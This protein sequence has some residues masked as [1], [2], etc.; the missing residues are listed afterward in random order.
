M[1]VIANVATWRDGRAL[2][3]CV[4]SI[5]G[6]VD[7][8]VLLP[9]VLE[10]L[11]P[12]LGDYPPDALED[13]DLG[14]YHDGTHVHVIGAP[15]GAWTSLSHKR[16]VGRQYAVNH[17]DADWILAIDADEILRNGELLRDTLR[18]SPYLAFPIPFVSDD[19]GKVTRAPWKVYRAGRWTH[20]AQSSFM[21]LEAGVK[22]VTYQLEP[23]DEKGLDRAIA[24]MLPYLE[25][26]PEW[27]PDWRQD[28]ALRLGF[29]ENHLEPPPETWTLWRSPSVF[30]PDLLAWRP[31]VHTDETPTHYCPAC[32]LRFF[33][34]GVCDRAH[35][36]TRVEPLPPPDA[37]GADD[38][39]PAADPAGPDLAERIEAYG[40]V[41]SPGAEPVAGETHDGEPAS[42][43]HPDT[44]YPSLVPRIAALEAG[45]E[46]VAVRLSSL[47]T[48]T[49]GLGERV[50]AFEANG[51]DA[52]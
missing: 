7:A 38:S 8:I 37:D 41:P 24:E 14:R 12:I 16:E 47:E 4:R 52:E 25:H 2:H 10:P 31:D 17:L 43:S 6:H 36:P 23:Q 22:S 34:P 32:G 33:A 50:R 9:G 29:T 27:R 45:L 18:T 42:V 30:L 46:N 44:V 13:E 28:P 48:Y 26:H 49:E 11:V 20:V 21:R 3:E 1:R 51:K 15:E 5:A 39:G 19:V 35:E 40:V